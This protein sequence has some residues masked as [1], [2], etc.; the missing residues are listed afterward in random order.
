MV[1]AAQESSGSLPSP[2][3]IRVRKVHVRG[4]EPAL[5]GGE[6]TA[7]TQ[8]TASKEEAWRL[9]SDNFH[10][11]CP[12]LMGRGGKAEAAREW[13]MCPPPPAIS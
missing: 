6:S 12:R 13:T 5:R 11:S 2:F 8:T 1:E 3:C 7:K 10:L 9:L 4:L